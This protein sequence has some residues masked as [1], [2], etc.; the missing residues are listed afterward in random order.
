L[1][2]FTDWLKDTLGIDVEDGRSIK[3]LLPEPCGQYVV[4]H[5]SQRP[6]NR[7]GDD[8]IYND[9]TGWAKPEE[10]GKTSS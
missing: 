9:V 5:V 2:R 10:F 6:S 8:T 7:D 3:E 4:A 1:Y